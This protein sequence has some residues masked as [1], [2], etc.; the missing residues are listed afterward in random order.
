MHRKGNKMEFEIGKTDSIENKVQ[1]NRRHSLKMLFCADVQLGAICT[2]NLNL[3]HKLE[4]QLILNE[5]LN[6]QNRRLREQITEL[7]NLEK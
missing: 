3:K 5:T 7:E 1:Q 6:T 4:E 2:E